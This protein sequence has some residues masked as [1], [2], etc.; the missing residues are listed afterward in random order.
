MRQ[1]GLQ[2]KKTA[3]QQ[4]LTVLRV[5]FGLGWIDLCLTTIAVTAVVYIITK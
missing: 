5:A 2:N 1:S 4:A 3:W